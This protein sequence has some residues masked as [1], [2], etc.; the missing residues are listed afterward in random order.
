MTEFLTLRS[1]SDEEF[2]RRVYVDTTGQ[3]PS[4][5]TAR[6]FLADRNPRKRDLLIDTLI[7]TEEFAEQ[8]GWLW[9]D[10]FRVRAWP[11]RGERG[12]R[13]GGRPVRGKPPHC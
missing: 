12:S 8:W 9:G 13:A 4:A 6:K 7:G 1:S 11:D 3:L 5:E 2:V 10:L